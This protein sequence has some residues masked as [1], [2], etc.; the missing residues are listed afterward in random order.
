MDVFLKYMYMTTYVCVDNRYPLTR[1][2]TYFRTTLVSIQRD[3]ISSTLVFLVVRCR[4]GLCHRVAPVADAR[5]MPTFGHVSHLLL[6]R[7][8]RLLVAASHLLQEN[9]PLMTSLE[10]AT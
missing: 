10:E 9:E 7:V 8:T 1:G 5:H 4:A 2:K 3:V 6:T